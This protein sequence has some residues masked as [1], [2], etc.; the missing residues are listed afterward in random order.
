MPDTSANNYN[1]EAT[2]PRLLPSGVQEGAARPPKTR[3]AMYR[4]IPRT[5]H[6]KSWM[7]MVPG[8]GSYDLSDEQARDARSERVRPIARP[9]PTEWQRALGV[10][11]NQWRTVVIFAVSFFAAV[12][13][14]TLAMRP[15]YEPEG[16]L[17]IDPPG[18][19]VFSLDAAG[20]GLIDAEYI[21]TEAEKLQ[22]DD[23]A[24]AT[25]A[26]LQL[27][28]NPEITGK[29][30]IHSPGNSDPLTARENAALRGLRS[31]LS[32]RRDPSSRLVV[33]TFGSHDPRLSA[34]VVNTLM[35]LLVQRN[36]ES[37]NKAIAES[38][39]WLSRQ[40]DDIR[41]KM[42]R[43]SQ[44]L[45]DFGEKTGI[46][47]VDP[48]T[49]TYSEKMGD[50]NKQLVQAEAD[51][52][53]F[54][55]FLGPSQNADSLPQVRSNLVIQ[56]LTQKRAELEAQLAQ[57]R[58]IY[59]PNHAE[60]RKL[61]NQVDELQNEISA[62]Q[63]AIV[64]ELWTNYR[65]ART[66]EQS[67]SG[68]VK[69][70]T[71]DLTTLSQYEVLKKEAQADRDLYDALYAKIKEA[72]ISAASKSS[73]IHIVNQARV[74]DH[75]TRPHRALNI[76]AGALFGL[77]GGVGLAFVKDRMQD[78]I[79]SA[80]DVREWAHFPSIAVVPA[81]RNGLERQGLLGGNRWKLVPLD[82]GEP[83]VRECYVLERPNSPEAEAVHA[84][85]TMLFLSDPK[86]PPRV[87][88]VTSPLP[89]EGKTTLAINLAITMAKH[90][91]TC[92]VDA[93]MR[94]PA[95]G[96]SFHLTSTLGL[97]HLL[98]RSATLDQVACAASDV[99]N[100]TIVPAANPTQSAIQLLSDGRMKAVIARLR[101]RF[102]FV[103]ID[104]PPILPYADGLAIS[105]HV[106]G[107]ILVGRAG[108]TPRG[109]ITRSMELLET[110]NSAPILTLVL[111]GVDE[112]TGYSSYSY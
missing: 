53:Q 5:I 1:G 56:G 87:L 21:S 39:V 45:A 18:S 29:L 41:E 50:L 79:H 67:L 37:R 72:G 107:V 96:T 4:R 62:Q 40:L 84:L 35:K 19:E 77:I 30:P 43:A 73:N 71:K 13:A 81:I 94:K 93:D 2:T 109:A 75:P 86:H 63:N 82:E 11:L 49:N 22:T 99:E 15:V 10:L 80:D 98:N 100:L 54:E 34:S 7:D 65:A 101:D 46:A 55:S 52:I 9:K 27:D 85:R 70:A 108:Q 48:N 104:T 17:Q 91:R 23:L 59:G 60:V 74:L 92:L 83:L 58:V 66:R 90:G 68:E 88:V 105:T 24:L 111:N 76:L 44:A 51:R 78:R 31:H 33:V 42:E 103:V 36:F 112:R 95:V 47:D 89:G 38:A 16:K 6:R 25:I 61:Q 97:E 32:V 14:V 20:A 57:S 69:L 8:Q 64:S 26:E 102:E 12:T 106:D 28:K 3:P 110:I